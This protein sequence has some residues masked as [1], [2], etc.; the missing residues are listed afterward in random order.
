MC[1][2]LSPDICSSDHYM[3]PL[4]RCLINC[5]QEI[6]KNPHHRCVIIHEVDMYKDRFLAQVLE[7]TGI[8]ESLLKICHYQQ[9]AVRSITIFLYNN[10]TYSR[11]LIGSRPVIY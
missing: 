9:N 10:P 3:F 1:T 2:V 11:I 6:N 8:D 4:S 7:R 5:H